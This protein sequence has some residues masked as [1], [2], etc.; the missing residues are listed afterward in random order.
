MRVLPAE[1]PA[2]VRRASTTV[3]LGKHPLKPS[4]E[5]SDSYDSFYLTVMRSC[6]G[7]ADKGDTVQ[8]CQGVHIEK[9]RRWGLISVDIVNRA[10][11]EVFW[12]G[13]LHRTIY[14]LTDIRGTTQSGNGETQSL[15]LKPGN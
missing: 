5:M 14:P 11:G 6:F 13:D 10:P 8:R 15:R 4:F 9:S 3:R 7:N 12:Q 1:R 2:A